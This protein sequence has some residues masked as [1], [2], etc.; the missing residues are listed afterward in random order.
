MKIV[1]FGCGPFAP[2]GFI[3]LDGS[4]VALASRLPLP[5]VIF[6]PKATLVSAMRRSGVRY[7]TA[8]RVRFPFDSL[9]GVYA[10]HVLEHLARAECDA[11]LRKVHAWLKPDGRLRVVLPDLSLFASQYSSGQ[12]DADHFVACT[13]LSIERQG[14]LSR[15]FGHSFHQWM[16]DR[17]S[18]SRIL[19]HAGFRN[20]RVCRFC[21]SDYPEFN[22]L[23]G[24][25]DRAADSFYLEATK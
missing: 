22:Q 11:L 24:S 3:N 13:N 10:S 25:A 19:R 8:R 14:W 16:Y 6:G 9:D 2:E 7:A 23:D 4:P 1:N 5:A 15:C 17:D 21:G 18:G 20:I 12:V